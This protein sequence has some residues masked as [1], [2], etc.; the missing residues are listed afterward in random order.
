MII[1]M[2]IAGLL[3]IVSGT[4][5]ADA[6][7]GDLG[8]VLTGHE[9]RNEDVLL[10]ASDIVI[11]RFEFL[12]NPD[13]GPAGA[14][15][16]R[17]AKVEILSSLEGNLS[18]NLLADYHVQYGPEGINE[19]MPIIGTPYILFIE[20]AEQGEHFHI[21]KMLPQSEQNVAS[22]KALLYARSKR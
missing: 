6:S 20:K 8:P 5:P 7:N 18:G 16:Y 17:H 13:L 2:L 11:A 12:G 19:T 14:V 10:T 3:I 21:E 22:V 9:K 15:A 4:V 1:R